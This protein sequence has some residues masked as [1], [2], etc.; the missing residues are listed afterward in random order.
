MGGQPIFL[1]VSR[2]YHWSFAVLYF[3]LYLFMIFGLFNVIVAIYVDN[4]M[5]AAKFDDK[6]KVQ[7]RLRD[8]RFFQKKMG[9]LTDLIWEVCPQLTVNGWENRATCTVMLEAAMQMEMK[10][11]DFDALRGDFRFGRILDDLD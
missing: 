2:R 7:S 6:I 3:V 4:V 10:R 5:T 11:Q 1:K 9:Q 8:K